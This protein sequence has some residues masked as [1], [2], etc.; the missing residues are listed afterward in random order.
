MKLKKVDETT[1]E[2]WNDE[3][4][5]LLFTGDLKACDDFMLQE[6]KK[7]M[8]NDPEFFINQMK[9][10]KDQLLVFKKT[11]EDIINQNKNNGDD[12]K[13]DNPGENSVK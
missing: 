13:N 7:L 8:E 11:I 9:T 4:T 5:T 2:V 6:I 3:E 1:H 12:S 10:F